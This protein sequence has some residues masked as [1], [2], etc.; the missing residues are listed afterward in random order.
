[1]GYEKYKQTYKY[2]KHLRI[3]M[4]REMTMMLIR[5]IIITMMLIRTMIMTMMLIR[6]MIMTMMLIRN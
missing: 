1:M 6:T 5:T 2:E 3:M 4:M